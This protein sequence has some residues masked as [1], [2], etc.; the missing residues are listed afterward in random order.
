MLAVQPL[1]LLG[2]EHAGARVHPLQRESLDQ[3]RDGH[4]RRVVVKAPA[5][6]RE[7]VDE[8]LRQHSAVAELLHRDGAVA[9][10]EL[11]LVGAEHHGQVRVRGRLGLEGGVDGELARRRRQQVLAADDVGDAH[12]DVIE[13]VR[14]EVRRRPVGTEDDVVAQ[15]RVVPLDPAAD[16]VV[17][18]ARAVGRHGQADDVRQPRRLARGAL[19]GRQA[20]A[21]PRVDQGQAGRLA[22]LPLGCKLVGRA[23]ARVGGPVLD[24]LGRRGRIEVEPL[25]L[26]VRAV[27][28]VDPQPAEHILG[29]GDRLLGRPCPVGVLEAQDHAAAGMARVEPVEEHRARVPDVEPPG[30]AG[31]HADDGRGHGGPV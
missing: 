10:G 30:R 21:A 20:P 25:G 14:E 9:L 22:P 31:R 29:L 17:D 11:L 27:V 26:A 1:E 18:R 5:D 24:Q 28:P 23:V 7:V 6:E 12:A 8:R 16:D 2:I 4:H 3:L 13:R 19:L 15:E